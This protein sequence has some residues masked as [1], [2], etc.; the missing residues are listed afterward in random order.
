MSWFEESHEILYHRQI[1]F[2]E[3]HLVNEKGR[4]EK[5]RERGRGEEGR[6]RK[7]RDGVG[8]RSSG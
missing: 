4:S 1:I 3:S 7:K 5:R 8:W 2:L 6:M